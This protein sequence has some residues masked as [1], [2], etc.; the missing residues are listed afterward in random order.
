MITL[1]PEKL[2]EQKPTL[3]RI[4]ELLFPDKVITCYYNVILPKPKRKRYKEASQDMQDAGALRDA[5]AAA[6][7]NG[8][9]PIPAAEVKK[10]LGL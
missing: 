4:G 7:A 9:K 2:V 5:I 1:V 8:E 6:E 10:H 3:H